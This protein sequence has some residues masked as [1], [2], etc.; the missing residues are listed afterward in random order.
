MKRGS[1]TKNVYGVMA[2]LC[3]D[4]HFQI[5]AQEFRV[6]RRFLGSMMWN[7]LLGWGECF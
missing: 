5:C 3:V 4:S 6:Y 7:L 1:P 2:M